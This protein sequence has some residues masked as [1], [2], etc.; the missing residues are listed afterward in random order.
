MPNIVPRSSGSYR[1]IGCLSQIEEDKFGWLQ[2]NGKLL[3]GKK[4]W[5]RG[6]DLN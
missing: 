6:V 1:L 4:F 2:G 3:R 5:L